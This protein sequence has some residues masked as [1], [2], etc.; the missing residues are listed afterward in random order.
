VVGSLAQNFN[1]NRV[2]KQQLPLSLQDLADDARL[3]IF[4]INTHSTLRVPHQEMCSL[5]DCPPLARPIYFRVS[6][7]DFKRGRWGG[8]ENESNFDIGFVF[9]KI[10]NQC[11]NDEALECFLHLLR[12]P[13]FTM[14]NIAT[15]LLHLK[16]FLRRQFYHFL[17][18]RLIHL[19]Q[20]RI[21]QNKNPSQKIPRWPCITF[22][23]FHPNEEVQAGIY[24]LYTP[25]LDIFQEN[26]KITLFEPIL[27]YLS[28]L[29]NTCPARR[30]SFCTFLNVQKHYGIFSPAQHNHVLFDRN[31]KF[32]FPKH[33]FLL[34]ETIE[35]ER[36]DSICTCFICMRSLVI[37]TV[38]RFMHTDYKSILE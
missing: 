32:L 37:P 1:F 30:E 3:E 26:I 25:Q 21:V 36:R 38:P 28:C 12:S 17:T 27:N 10:L 22:L 6:F 23:T 29:I 14:Y 35:E 34:L 20:E 15:V 13:W 9:S 2:T 24:F 33:D 11:N 5:T 16:P 18:Q 7:R 19:S 8:V 4:R 31:W